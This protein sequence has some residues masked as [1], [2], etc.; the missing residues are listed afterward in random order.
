MFIGPIAAGSKVVASTRSVTYKHL[1]S[2]YSDAL[3]VEME[4]YGF[5]EA[6]HANPQMDALVV[7]GISDLIDKKTEEDTSGSQEIAAR[8]AS[9]F[10]FEVLANL[11]SSREMLPKDGPRLKFSTDI[12]FSPPTLAEVKIGARRSWFIRLKVENDG[13]ISAKNCSGRLLTVLNGEL[14]H[15]KQFDSLDLYWTRQDKPENYKPLD[16]RGGGDFTYLDIAQ[17][18]EADNALLP[19][20][21]I[22]EGHRLVTP[23]GWVGRPRDLLPGTYYMLIAIYADDASIERTWFRIEWTDDYSVQ[24]YPCS[25]LVEDPPVR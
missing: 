17:I 19:R 22:P 9:A 21:V 23:S 11:F 24:P 18:K 3:A 8:N 1:R 20:V 5:L 25:I 14:N 13:Q 6:V 10:A 2:N 12:D 7:R 16:I 4:G 15:L